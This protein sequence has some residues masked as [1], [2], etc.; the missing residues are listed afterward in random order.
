MKRELDIREGVIVVPARIWG[1]SGDTMVRLCLD[2][3][4]S[5]VAL[6]EST[7]RHL[8]YD[9]IASG[10]RRLTL[11]ASG[12]HTCALV[13]VQGI[14]ALG[15]LSSDVDVI[16]HDLPESNVVDGLLGLSFLRAYDLHVSFRRRYIQLT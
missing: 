11:T 16:C 1:P 6:P 5:A 13:R 7:L 14:Q 9:P 15:Q 4:S 12:R 8:G 2:T 3:G 10:R